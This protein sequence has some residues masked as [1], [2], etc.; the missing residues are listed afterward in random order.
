SNIFSGFD[1][2]YIYTNLFP[3]ANISYKHSEKTSFSLLYSRR[4]R[5]PAGQDLNPVLNIIDPNTSWGGDP[6]LLPEYTDNVEL[7]FSSLGGYLITTLNYAYTDNPILWVSKVDAQSLYTISGNRNLEHSRNMGVATTANFPI[8][9]WWNTNNYVYLYHNSITGDLGFG[10]TNN[11]S[12]SWMFNSTQSFK[13]PKGFNMEVSGNYEAPKAY[14]LGRGSA[15]W[16]ANIS[17]QK[18]ILKEKGSVKITLTDMFY[19][20]QYNGKFN[21]GMIE[22]KGGYRWD[23]RVL[24]VTLNYKF[25]KRLDK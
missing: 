5:R 21:Y 17:L 22:Q 4:I 23:N 7:A 11:R 25:G 16:Q 24:M 12:V 18:K 20:M 3:S 1:G 8:T 13:F 6:Y 10:M 15:F 9:K 19:S 14:A 2:L